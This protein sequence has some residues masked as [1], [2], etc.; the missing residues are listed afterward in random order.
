[1]SIKRKIS[2]K[3]NGLI[4]RSH[5]YSEEQFPDCK[6]FWNYHTFNTEIVN[7][8]STSALNAFDYDGLSIKGA[9]WALRHNPLSGDFAIL[10]NYYGYLNPQGSYVIIPLCVFSSLAGRYNFMEDRFYTLIYPSSIPHFSYRRQQAV[11]AFAASPIRHFPLFSVYT[12]LKR[13]VKGK[14]QQ[15]M[16]EEQMEQDAS[17]WIKNWKHE[18][19]ISDFSQPLSLLNQDGVEDAIKIL[20]EMIAF[21]KQRNIKPVLVL[22]P[23]YH[24]LAEKFTPDARH[25]CLDNMLARLEDQTVPFLNYMD[26]NQFVKNRELFQNSFLLNGNGSKL[27]TRRVLDDLKIKY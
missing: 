10:K 15:V 14:M 20:N 11:K 23:M 9:N 16:S 4:R 6:K 8:G 27:F 26:D 17:N 2:G 18:F 24:T 12:E 5:W 3:L 21:C 13:L 19:S 7:L 22:P 1:M 25:I